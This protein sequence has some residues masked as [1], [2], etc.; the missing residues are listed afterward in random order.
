MYLMRLFILS[1]GVVALASEGLIG[2]HAAG[3]LPQLLDA[4]MEEVIAGLEAKAFTST[5]LVRV[6]N[7]F[8]L[9]LKQKIKMP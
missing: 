4:T 9:R 3:A 8:R 6:S 7:G 1:T 5:D 2:F